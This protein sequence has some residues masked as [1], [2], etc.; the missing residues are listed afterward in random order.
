MDEARIGVVENGADLFPGDI[1]I[2]LDEGMEAVGVKVV[3]EDR[4]GDAG[5]AEAERA[6]HT[7]GVLPEGLIDGHGLLYGTGRTNAPRLVPQSLAR[8]PIMGGGRKKVLAVDTSDFRNGM[9]FYMDGD[10]WTIVE[11][12]HVKPG[13]G[14]AFVRT[15]LRKVRTGQQVEKTFRSGEKVEPAY[16]DK[17]EMQYLYKQQ[18]TAVLMDMD[19]YEQVEVPMES[20][21]DQAPFLKD[22]SAIVAL[23]AG[24]ETLGYELPSFVELE[25]VETDPGVKG[26]TVS[27]GA[28]K[29]AK[30]ETGAMV[31]VP[32]HINPG[33]VLKIDTRTGSYLERVKK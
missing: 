1:R 9:H 19:T 24:D 27:G 14:G 28:T 21:G 31:N 25:V 3:E 8:S 12:Q 11:F 26:D 15:K 18:K 13:K 29:P 23:R 32:F 20:L 33:D 5:V 4:D 30:M 16:V 17:V 10:V 2:V 6:A 22:E 7:I